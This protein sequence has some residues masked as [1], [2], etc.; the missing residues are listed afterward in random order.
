MNQNKLPV[1]K[2]STPGSLSVFPKA[3][4][5]TFNLHHVNNKAVSTLRQTLLVNGKF[6]LLNDAS[7]F[8]DSGLIKITAPN[9]DDL[10]GISE[11]IFYGRKIGDQLHLLQ[12]GYQ[13]TNAMT[14]P[15]G[16][17]VTCPLMAE[18]HNAIK[19]AIMMI[20]K[21]IGTKDKPTSDSING[22]L[23]HLEN[24]WLSPKPVF[25]AYPRMG[26]GPLIVTFHNFS[27]G[28]GSKFLWDF[29]DGE[30]S[31]K[32]HPTHT[33]NNEG[34]FTVRLTMIAADGAHALTE[35]TDYIEV[36]NEETPA[37]FYVTPAQGQTTD[38]FTFVDQST[39]SIAERHWF[40][41][42]GV[43]LTVSNPNIHTVTHKYDK[44]GQY[45]PSLMIRFKDNRIKK[46][47]LPEEIEVV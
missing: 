15:A 37:F 46:V 39:G 35:K 13:K 28:F 10:L 43:D 24:K 3:K 30:T 44:P 22:I 6:M 42:D 40:F 12:R 21:K 38:E 1:N 29:G 47:F 20:E 41:G 34:K 26:P 5:T 27:M 31:S 14:W 25:K 18:H 2:L 9:S 45:V 23:T 36:N 8:P 17:K 11:V 32:Q 33:Y 7:R 19:D 4:D 16:S